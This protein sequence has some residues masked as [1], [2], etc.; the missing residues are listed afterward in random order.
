MADT[1]TRSNHAQYPIHP[2]P[3]TDQQQGPHSLH[4]KSSRMPIVL[5]THHE[6]HGG[7]PRYLPP[8][9]HYVCS[10]TLPSSPDA[11]LSLPPPASLGDRN[12]CRT[13]AHALAWRDP[14]HWVPLAAVTVCFCLNHYPMH[15]SPRGG[16]WRNSSVRPLQ[17]RLFLVYWWEDIDDVDDIFENSGTT[18][19]RLLE[20]GIHVLHNL[21]KT[22]LIAPTAVH[23]CDPYFCSCLPRRC[24]AASNRGFKL[25]ALKIQVSE[26]R[27]LEV[28]SPRRLRR[29]SKGPDCATLHCIRRNF[30]S[31]HLLLAYGRLVNSLYGTI[32]TNCIVTWIS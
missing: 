28:L 19:Q 31:V 25:R 16:P 3:M 4:H 7:R 26:E 9:L 1:G 6:V 8:Q 32:S 12:S 29:A 13:T 18:D 11:T 5:C 2:R 17:P 15:V 10:Y 30:E 20:W 21:E 27:L 23:R 24:C 22:Y 14:L